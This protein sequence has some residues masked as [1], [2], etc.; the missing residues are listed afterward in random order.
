M[1]VNNQNT[2]LYRQLLPDQDIVKILR[3]TRKNPFTETWKERVNN[4]SPLGY[5]RSFGLW[6]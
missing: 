3:C 6:F 5:F 1:S 4:I 2:K